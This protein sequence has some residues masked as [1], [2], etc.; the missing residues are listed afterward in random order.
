M[1]SK[2]KQIILENFMAFSNAVIDFDES[3]IINLKGY[4]DSGKSSIL[5][6]IAVCLNNFKPN[7]QTNWIKDD[8][9]FF[10]VTINFDDGVTIE[11]TKLST[12]QSLYEMYKNGYLVYTSKI[13]NQLT[14][15]TDVPEVISNYLNLAKL[16]SGILNF[17]TNQD[18]QFLAQ[19]TGRENFQDLNNLFG[20]EE[21]I[22][23]INYCKTDIS[24]LNTEIQKNSTEIEFLEGKV[25]DSEGIGSEELAL[26]LELENGLVKSISKS[27]KESKI[28]G[29][30]SILKTTEVGV[31]IP[32]INSSLEKISE[33]GSL[34]GVLAEQDLPV[35]NEVDSKKLESLKSVKESCIEV[36]S[37]ES[38]VGLKEV[39]C[40]KLEGLFDI[41]ELTC[42]IGDEIP[43]LRTVDV[44]SLEALE[45]IKDC[46]CDVIKSS[47]SIKEIETESLR[48]QKVL[49]KVKGKLKDSGVDLYECPNCGAFSCKEYINVK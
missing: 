30:I 9:K 31:E 39:P 37:D 2:I 20:I 33:L 45:G 38:L 4:S 28:L 42:V 48:Y 16:E 26:V 12:G 27:G 36:P 13:N 11:R 44:S 23:A 19:T 29:D 18:K 24:Y 40:R 5:I 7:K 34:I 41:K 49:E 43:D 10:K 14:P 17:R 46:L 35:I 8:C 32:L 22:W 6:A 3:G 25:K 21:I 47:E 1:S 15:I